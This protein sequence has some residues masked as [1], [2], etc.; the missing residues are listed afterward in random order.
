[1][2][3]ASA[4]ERIGANVFDKISGYLKIT[5]KFEGKRGQKIY[6]NNILLSFLK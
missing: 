2:D 5:L 6:E 1:M 3:F 4:S